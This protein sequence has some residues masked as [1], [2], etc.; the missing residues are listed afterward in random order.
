MNAISEA[1][2]AA[3]KKA[4]LD[5]KSE[6][7][8]AADYGMRLSSVY[9]IMGGRQPKP[10]GTAVNGQ[11]RKPGQRIPNAVR[12]A[13]L[14]DAANS[15]ITQADIARKHGVSQF[16]VSRLLNGVGKGMRQRKQRESCF[17]GRRLW[18]KAETLKAKRMRRD[19]M[20][21]E[22]IGKALDRTAH[23][24]EVR[25]QAVSG[26][27]RQ[28]ALKAGGIK[29]AVDAGYKR[30]D[31]AKTFGVSLS[32]VNHVCQGRAP[33]VAEPAPQAIPAESKAELK[34]AVTGAQRVVEG[35]DAPKP[36][37]DGFLGRVQ[38]MAALAPAYAA[39]KSFVEAL[40]RDDLDEAE[41]HYAK[42][43]GEA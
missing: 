9:S 33:D 36:K 19:G 5:G 27:F 17:N 34:A 8:V 18:T 15:E 30:T 20:S 38:R 23:G 16:F 4:V 42:L 24:V 39:A 21:F 7:S 29:A 40:D 13:I 43:R 6:A 28:G 11:D 25:L 1:V 32:K 35:S 41:A 2:K 22:A 14:S 31:V 12:A 26:R 37:T 10:N 3:V